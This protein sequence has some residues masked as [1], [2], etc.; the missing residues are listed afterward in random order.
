MHNTICVG[1]HY[2]QTNTNNVNKTSTL[3]QT[4]GD[5][6]DQKI[7]FMRRKSQRTSQHRT[8]NAKTHDRTTQ[9]TKKMTNKNPVVKSGA[10]EG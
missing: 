10:R 8:H 1:N 4:T 6:N 9:K 5:K 7:V 2:A 3:L